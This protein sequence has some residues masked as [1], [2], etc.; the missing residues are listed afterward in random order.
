MKDQEGN[1]LAEH[2]QQARHGHHEA[3]ERFGSECAGQSINGW[4]LGYY[5]VELTAEYDP[6]MG[7]VTIELTNTLSE[8]MN[9]ES[10][11]FGDVEIDIG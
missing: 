2:T 6:A 1:V 3:D 10:I 9:N 8:D 5:N 4:D 11:G 7:D